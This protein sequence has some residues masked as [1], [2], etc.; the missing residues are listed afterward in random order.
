MENNDI[1]ISTSTIYRA[2]DNVILPSQLRKVLRIKGRRRHG[3]RKKSPCGHLNIEY[4]IRDRPKSVEN[5]TQIGH[6]ESDT[7]RGAKLSG[8]LATHVEKKSRFLVV[9]KIANQ[10][11]QEFTEATIEVLQMIPANKVKSITCDHGKE[12]SKHREL[13]EKL[14]CKV[15][16]ADP[17]AP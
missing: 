10:T 12:F 7:V 11:A 2:L 5:R 6:W 17:Y 15:Y 8:S 16:F 14:G 13:S 3:G 9:V 1:R 4:T